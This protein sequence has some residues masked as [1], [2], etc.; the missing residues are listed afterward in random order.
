MMKEN[1]ALRRCRECGTVFERGVADPGPYG[2]PQCFLLRSHEV[3]V[4]DERE[5]VIRESTPFR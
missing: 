5:R 2:C 4:V 1:E 3:L